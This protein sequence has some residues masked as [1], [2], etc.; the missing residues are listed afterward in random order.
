MFK[1]IEN[2]IFSFLATLGFCTLFDTPKEEFVYCGI[3]SSAGWLVYSVLYYIFSLDRI[4][5]NF[6]AML[7]VALLSEIFARKNMKPVTVYIIPGIIC[8]VPGYGIY[9]TM[10][11]TI[12]GEYVLA[13]KSLIDTTFIAWIIAIS[14]VIVSAI[15]K[16][17]ACIKA[18]KE[19]I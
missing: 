18:K 6:P 3:V 15:F 14:M 1:I 10:S 9:N 16:M 11:Y 19:V 4:W 17:R 5:S 8:F 7:M 2:I 13:T 12:K